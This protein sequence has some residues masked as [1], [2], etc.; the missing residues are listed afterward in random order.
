MNK[1]IEMYWN[2]MENLIISLVDQPGF[3]DEI[4]KIDMVRFKANISRYSEQQN[5]EKNAENTLSMFVEQSK[6]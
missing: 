4:T 2:C 3:P 1:N 6:N 5:G